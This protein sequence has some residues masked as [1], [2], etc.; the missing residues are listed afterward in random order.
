MALSDTLSVEDFA[1]Q[2]AVQDCTLIQSFYQQSSMTGG[3]ERRYADRAPSMWG[4]TVTTVPMEVADSESLMVLIN[5]R[6]GG[7][8]TVLAYNYR[9]P[10]PPN[11][12]DGSGL[13]V[14]VPKLGAITDR[15]HVAF[16]G[17]PPGY[18]VRRGT[19]FGVVYDTSRYYLGQFAEDKTA[20][21]GGNFTAAEIWPPL[22]PL[23]SGTLDVVL[24][25]PPAKFKIIPGSAYP[26]KE[27]GVLST[28]QFDI[29]QTYSR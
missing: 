17:F 4:A 23:V 24:K 15:L 20:S 22:P 11:D 25:K 14:S 26:S 29:E 8:K 28:I 18:T 1:D 6:G 13:G 21:V 12:P 19:Y 5:S 3:G 27:D 7:V 9:M 16:T 2:F 10:Y